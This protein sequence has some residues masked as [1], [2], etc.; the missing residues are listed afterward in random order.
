MKHSLVKIAV[1]SLFFYRKETIY[2][3]LI[4]SILAAIICGSLLTGHSVR[5]SLEKNLSQKLGNADIVISSGLRYFDASLSAR[6]AEKSGLKTVPVIETDGYCQNF[7]TGATAPDI[8]IYGTDE[9][10]FSF[11]GSLVSEIKKGSA[12]IN[13]S[14]SRKLGLK[15][16]DE[17]ILRFSSIDPLPSNAPFA[18]SEG[19]AGSKVLRVAGIIAGNEAG[20]F[21]LGTNQN[22]PLNIFVTL[23]DLNSGEFTRIKSNRLLIHNTPDKNN[24]DLAKTLRETITPS[25]IGLSVRLSSKTGEPELISDR[26][27]I[28][29]AITE[30]VIRLIPSSSPVITYLANTFRVRTRETPYSFITALPSAMYSG[31]EDDEIVIN[32]WLADD[33]EAKPGDTLYLQWFDPSGG[34][35]LREKSWSFIIK[36]IEEDNSKYSDPSL[37]PDFPGISGRSACSDWD[38]GVQLNMSRIR[39]KDEDYWNRY[40]GTPKAFIN[41]ETGKRLWGNNFGPATA[42]RFHAEMDTSRIINLL[43]GQFDPSATGFTISDLNDKNRKAASSGVDFGMLFISLSFFII[44]SCIILLFMALSLFLDSRK[45]EIRIYYAL[46]FR[47]RRISALIFYEAFF[48]SVLGAF[49]GAFLG[50]LVNILIIIALNGVWTGAVQTDTLSPGFGLISLLAGFITTLLI[51]G[52]LTGIKLK[53]FLKGLAIGSSTIIKHR[54]Q[55]KRSVALLLTLAISLV[56]LALS[57]ILRSYATVLAFSGGSLL[58][59]SMV[60]AINRFFT[61]D[62]GMTIDYSRLY[63]SFYPSKAVTPVIFLAAGI[64]AVI[65]TS[66]NR[67]V[68]S[69]KMMMPQGGTGGFLLW[70]ESAIPVDHDLNSDEGR[71]EFGFDDD[72]I[73]E[74]SFIQAKRL[75]GDDAS[76]LNITHVTSPPILGLEPTPFIT[77]GSFSFASKLKK[78]KGINP[79]SLL[80]ENSGNNIIYGIADQTVLQWGLKVKPGD[81][82]KYRAENG[83]PLNI[84]ICAGLKSSVFQGYLL[85]GKENFDKYFPSVAGNSVF[86]VDGNRASSD[87][88]RNT[89]EERLAGYG[90]SI[91]PMLDKLASF[92]EVTNT[93]LK[94]FVL[95]GAFGM[96]LGAAGLGF[97]LMRNFS[98]RKREFALMMASG[99]SERRIRRLLLKDHLIILS[100]GLLTGSVSAVCATW[101]SMKSGAD[102]SWAILLAIPGLTFAIGFITLSLSVNQI[103][104]LNLVTNLRKE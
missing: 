12:L 4:V 52:I 30:Q 36:A 82:L 80:N 26:I 72:G 81:T 32:R 29:S 95:L 50:Y 98:S 15:T 10:F 38:A 64:F 24:P 57:A 87:L 88:Y 17:L 8:K 14:L 21:S 102:I 34:K 20:N 71:R 2:Q 16:G 39:K 55:G 40:K 60:L 85:T 68:V 101:P 103:S 49:A 100:W 65:I 99:Y 43:S 51:S 35:T 58:F 66:A 28:D 90:V 19:T 69:E 53:S 18:P 9:S 86:L 7:N 6:F 11:H 79:W 42:I 78:E 93:Y 37:M 59:I 91:E 83:Q 33:L 22:I 48:I 23:E 89:I 1:R 96:I 25:D 97:I 75:R 76:C 44:L 46:G 47:N 63:Y 74:I 13:E 5:R 73:K 67:Q 61:S 54:T 62:R 27:F 70:A 92:F 77:K 56:I 84:V 45:D 104:K 94:V 3:V 41:Y 31:I